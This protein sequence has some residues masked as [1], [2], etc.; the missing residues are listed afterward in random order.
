[1]T[2]RKV[3]PSRMTLLWTCWRE[4]CL[5][6]SVKSTRC[7]PIV[8]AEVAPHPCGTT[9]LAPHPS[10]TTP[11]SPLLHHTT[12]IRID[13]TWQTK[14]GAR[15]PLPPPIPSSPHLGRAPIAQAYTTTRQAASSLS[16]SGRW[17]SAT[18]AS[19]W[20]QSS[21]P[22]ACTNPPIPRRIQWCDTSRAATS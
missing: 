9:P 14:R 8:V 5:P 13:S 11:Q 22:K 10:C 20:T 15:G 7:S 18:K 1:M 3:N 19:S 16:P 12:A 2:R 4:T 17:H 21:C 6:A